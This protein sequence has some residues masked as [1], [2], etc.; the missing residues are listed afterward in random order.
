[1]I[2]LSIGFLACLA[3]FLEMAGRA[4]SQEADVLVDERASETRSAVDADR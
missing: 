4:P 1:M 2:I 3:V